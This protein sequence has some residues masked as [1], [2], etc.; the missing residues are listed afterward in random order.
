MKRII[1]LYSITLLLILQTNISGQ[2]PTIVDIEIVDCHSFKKIIGM[3]SYYPLGKFLRKTGIDESP[4]LIHVLCGKMSL[5]GPRPLINEDLEKI[6]KYNPE[7]INVRNDLKSKPGI[8]GLWQMEKSKTLSF[9][10]LIKFDTEYELNKSIK[11]EIILIVKTIY[12]C[13]FNAFTKDEIPHQP[14]STIH[15][16]NEV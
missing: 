8:S 10:E 15:K 4:Q 11:N 1:Y 2:Q 16:L 5:I 3:D 14:L 6:M 9:D 12:K 7:Y 13:A